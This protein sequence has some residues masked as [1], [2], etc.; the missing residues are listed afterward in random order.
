MATLE[1]HDLS[2]R[3]GDT[4]AVDRASLAVESGEFV[5][6]LG[7]SG[8]GKTTILR[9]IAGLVEPDSGRIVIGGADRT[10]APPEKRDI[11]LVFQS[12]A[13]F[14][15]MSVF[16]NVAFGLRQR[17]VAHDEIDR[18][19]AEALELVRLSG[20]QARMPR[21]LS[22]G[23]QQ[24]VALA[25]AIAP[26]P[27]LL[28]LD[29]PLSNLDAKL[30]DTMRIE[31]RLLQ[32]QLRIST[33]FVTHDQEEALT[34]SDRICV[35]NGGRIE[36]V[37][38]PREVYD[39]PDTPFVASFFGRSTV[40]DGVVSGAGEAPTVEVPGIGLLKVHALP[41]G[42]KVGDAVRLTLRRE[43]M[44]LSFTEPARTDNCFAGTLELSS[45]AGNSLVH[46]VRLDAGEALATEAR[47]ARGRAPPAGNP[48]VW[49]SIEAG[50][51]I[52]MRR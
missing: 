49:I 12:Y 19:V 1:I 34:M 44:A 4:I 14:P 26:R 2:K 10:W 36:Q 32:Q 8:C 41:E 21:E 29:E 18:R 6:L 37:G 38:T 48:R 50:D 33:V 25:R 30:R 42:G 9:M 16:E 13:L 47:A 5:S 23:Q 39:H 20:L 45:F 24:R 3:Y 11:G 52:A 35:L 7:P 46:V 22:G 15:H 43:S 40:V 28:L 17:R 51:V 27:T 31:L